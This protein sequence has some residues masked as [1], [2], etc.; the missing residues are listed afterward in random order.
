MFR[1]RIVTP[2]MARISRELVTTI[3]TPFDPRESRRSL[4][5]M[6]SGLHSNLNRIG[7]HEYPRRRRLYVCSLT[8]IRQ[9]INKSSGGLRG[10]TTIEAVPIDEEGSSRKELTNGSCRL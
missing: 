10:V 1:A 9:L 5:V 2:R 7:R 6:N 4:P 3:R 8:V